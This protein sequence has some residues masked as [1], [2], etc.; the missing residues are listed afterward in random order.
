VSKTRTAGF[1]L[2]I[3]LIARTY[4][5]YL[6]CQHFPM[7]INHH[8]YNDKTGHNGLFSFFDTAVHSVSDDFAGVID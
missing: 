2:L 4:A 5:G 7:R 3:S 8:V 1:S 6:F